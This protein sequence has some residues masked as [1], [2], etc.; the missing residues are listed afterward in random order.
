[1]KIIY[2]Y[3]KD[4]IKDNMFKIILRRKECVIWRGG[5]GKWRECFDW[6]ISIVY[7][8]IFDYEM[9]IYFIWLLFSVLY[10]RIIFSFHC[11]NFC[12]VQWILSP[13]HSANVFLH[14]HNPFALTQRRVWQWRRCGQKGKS[15]MECL[16]SM[17]VFTIK[18]DIM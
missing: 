17:D 2:L 13:F 11:N 12:T 16:I 5:E 10:C 3:I 4:D 14:R 6:F 7:A 15:V 8:D 1:M 18:W 9:I